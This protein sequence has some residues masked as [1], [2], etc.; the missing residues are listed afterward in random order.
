MDQERT[1]ARALYII[2]ALVLSLSATVL[3]AEEATQEPGLGIDTS[4]PDLPWG[5]CPAFMP[6]GCQIAVLHGD[7]AQ[8]NADVLFKVP[9]KSSIPWHR[10]S[11]PRRMVL[12]SGE[13]RLTYENQKTITLKPGDYSYAPAKRRHDG[14]CVSRTSCVLFIAFESPL[15]PKPAAPITP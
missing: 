6:E 1:G 13:L 5:P 15:E 11:S 9:A 10:H 8:D 4:N 2:A 12:V 7:P 14:Y 3:S